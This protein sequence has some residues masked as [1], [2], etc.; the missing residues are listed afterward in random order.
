MSILNALDTKQM[1]STQDFPISEVIK[2]TLQSK[3]LEI[4]QGFK[5]S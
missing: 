1:S 3:V 5:N 2:G 4:L